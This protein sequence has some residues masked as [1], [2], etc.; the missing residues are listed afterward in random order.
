MKLSTS[1]LTAVLLATAAQAFVQ[2]RF[3]SS[4]GRWSLQASVERDTDKGA[5][6]ATDDAWIQDSIESQAVN[7]DIIIGP[8]QVLIYDTTLRG[9]Q[10][11]VSAVDSSSSF[12][13]FYPRV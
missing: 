10:Y 9:K 11:L 8:D 1:A 5:A 3:S 4:A 6:I 2:P 13:I 12:G 7:N